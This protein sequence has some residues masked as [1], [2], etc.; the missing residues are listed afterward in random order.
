MESKSPPLPLL[1]PV[2]RFCVRLG[3]SYHA[4]VNAVC[5]VGGAEPGIPTQVVGCALDGGCNATG[6]ERRNHLSHGIVAWCRSHGCRGRGRL[7]R[8]GCGCAGV[9]SVG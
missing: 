7:T 9:V 3:S 5:A 2:S 8:R 6:R 4:I 1:P